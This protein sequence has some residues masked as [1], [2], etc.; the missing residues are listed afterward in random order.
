MQGQW[1]DG[2]NVD[3]SD[4]ELKLSDGIQLTPTAVEQ[5]SAR[6]YARQFDGQVIYI[7]TY[8]Y[9]GHWMGA[10]GSNR[11]VYF[12]PVHERAVA[13]NLALKWRVQDLGQGEVL[14]ENMKYKYNYL[15][16]KYRS[17][18][19]YARAE[20]NSYPQGV[21]NMRF[22]IGTRNNRFNLIRGNEYLVHC[23]DFHSRMDYNYYS[24]AS[25]FRFYTPP[26]S[27]QFGVIA[28]LDNSGRSVKWT[29]QYVEEIGI[30]KTNGHQISESL[31]TEI[32]VEIKSAFSFG[33][34]HTIS[35]TTTSE[36]S[37][38]KKVSFTVSAEVPPGKIVQV[39]QLVG[40][41]GPFTVRAK[42]FKIVDLNSKGKIQNVAYVS[43]VGEY[44]F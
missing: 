11:D 41:Y 19:R 42:Y 17:Y 27:D 29:F 36:Q 31:T 14:L 37:Y 35:W 44:N 34:S 25:E 24:P 38:S 18:D 26:K 21:S 39:Q 5:A 6:D 15:L 13:E 3:E 16:A 30:S 9:R 22:K 43:D 1:S 23:C 7:E 33:M 8:E 40:S 20:F 4:M 10:P 28:T 32:G 2:G 12:Y